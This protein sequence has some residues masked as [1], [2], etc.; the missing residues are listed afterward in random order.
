MGALRSLLGVKQAAGKQAVSARQQLAVCV[1]DQGLH[2]TKRSD[3]L[4]QRHH[5]RGA[6]LAGVARA[7]GLNL[8]QRAQRR[9]GALAQLLGLVGAVALGHGLGGLLGARC[10]QGGVELL[11]QGTTP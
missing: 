5:V 10:K 1:H 11:S 7:S 8:P 9:G 2:Q 4:G 3:G 6:Q